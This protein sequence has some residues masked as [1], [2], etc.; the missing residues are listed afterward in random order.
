M[1][2]LMTDDRFKHQVQYTSIPY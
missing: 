2:V 1:A